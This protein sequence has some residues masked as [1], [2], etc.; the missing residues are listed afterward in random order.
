[1]DVLR[2]A[3]VMFWLVLVFEFVIEGEFTRFNF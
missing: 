2:E 3:L 1:M